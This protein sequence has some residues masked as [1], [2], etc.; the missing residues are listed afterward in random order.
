MIK[1]L[2]TM[3]LQATTLPIIG[4]TK[5]IFSPHPL[6]DLVLKYRSSFLKKGIFYSPYGFASMVINHVF[7]SCLA[8][9]EVAMRPKV[10]SM[11]ELFIC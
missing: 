9:M 11:P 8:T 6:I 10:D 1:T 5:L 7:F 3:L 4:K 2:Y